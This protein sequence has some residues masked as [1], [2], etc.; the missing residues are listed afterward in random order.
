[1]E[2]ENCGK[3]VKKRLMKL[4]HSQNS[5]VWAP[6]QLAEVTKALNGRYLASIDSSPDAVTLYDNHRLFQRRYGK[7]LQMKR[8]KPVYSIGDVVRLKLKKLKA[9]DKS[10]TANYT[11]EVYRVNLVVWGAPTFRYHLEDMNGYIV[12]GTYYSQDL[13]P[14]FEWPLN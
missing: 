7:L 3:L 12:D 6:E 4:M 10:Y 9:F 5:V 1:M 13:V 2:A 11:S 14:V 8:G